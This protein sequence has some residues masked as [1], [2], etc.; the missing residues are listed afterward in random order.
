MEDFYTHNQEGFPPINWE[1]NQ[2]GEYIAAFARLAWSAWQ[3]SQSGY[4]KKGAKK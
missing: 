4:T 3:A 2:D 1:M